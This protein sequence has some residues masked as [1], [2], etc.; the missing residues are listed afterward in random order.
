M[1]VFGS[2]ETR[3]I[4]TEGLSLFSLGLPVAGSKLLLRLALLEVERKSYVNARQRPPFV[5]IYYTQRS[6]REVI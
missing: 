5:G 3:L 6:G 1:R 4:A 2:T